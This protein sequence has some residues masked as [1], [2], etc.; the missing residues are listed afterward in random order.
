MLKKGKTDTLPSIQD[1]TSDWWNVGTPAT[2]SFQL[3]TCSCHSPA[4]KCSGPRKS[5][6]P[7]S[8]RA[9]PRD[10]FRTVDLNWE[11]AVTSLLTGTGFPRQSTHRRHRLFV[12]AWITL[13]SNAKSLSH[14]QPKTLTHP[15]KG[16]MKGKGRWETCRGETQSQQR[17]DS[18]DPA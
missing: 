6:S 8:P 2:I 14:A 4:L 13:E 5:K 12:P 16:K 7:T 17:D 1:K 10:T 18:F 11:F 3:S 9:S 15:G